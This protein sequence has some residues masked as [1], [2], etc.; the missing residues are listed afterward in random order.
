MHY[1]HNGSHSRRNSRGAK[2]YIGELA[3]YAHKYRALRDYA[4][5]TH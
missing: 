5:R 1:T 2:R 4:V 3:E